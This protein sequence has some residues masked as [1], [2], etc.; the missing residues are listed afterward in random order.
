MINRA[1]L[2]AVTTLV[3]AFPVTIHAQAAAESALTG[4]LSSSATLKAGSILNHS[5]NQAS[6][7][8]G[9]RIHERTST[10]TQVGAKRQ[11]PGTATTELMNQSPGS[12]AVVASGAN[13]SPAKGGI[14]VQGGESRCASVS[15]RSQAS[16][17]PTGSG[18]SSADCPR[19]KSE[20]DAA[21]TGKYKSFVTLSFPK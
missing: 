5:L 13:S 12:R 18:V 7:R 15:S 20:P 11:R 4:A 17:D 10:S 6:G 16:P 21:T 2:G 14:W 8:L 3:L 19:T 9:I 1:L